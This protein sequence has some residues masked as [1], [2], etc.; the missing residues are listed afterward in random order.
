MTFKVLVE[1]ILPAQHRLKMFRRWRTLIRPIDLART[2]GISPQT[3]RDYEQTGFIPPSS[4][5]PGGQRR[6]EERHLAALLAARAMITGFGWMNARRAMRL[7]HAGD[8]TAAILLVNE[9]HAELH[10]SR[11]D[12]E[13]TLAALREIA[14]P[15]MAHQESHQALPQAA[16]RARRIREA[17]G[18]V[19]VPTSALRFW[20]QQGLIRPRREPG[21]GYR[22][23]DAQQLHRLRVLVLLRRSGYGV[24]AVRPILDDLELGET[25]R[26]VLAAERRVEDLAAAAEACVAATAA[27]WAY[28]VEHC[29]RT[30]RATAGNR[31]ATSGDR[32]SE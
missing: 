10:Q 8:I 23:Y 9:R 6:Y 24:E 4:R 15:A 13:A 22:L 31:A 12:A 18:L 3:V 28:V 5:T 26:A 30:T 14:Q 2:A 29:S 20:E 1:V 7:A 32:L 27:F 25:E 11:L 21:S 16:R 19:G 17:A